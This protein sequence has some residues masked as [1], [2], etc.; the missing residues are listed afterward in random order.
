[1][2]E[3]CHE[4]RIGSAVGSGFINRVL[5]PVGHTQGQC[6]DSPNCSDPVNPDSDGQSVTARRGTAKLQNRKAR[7][8]RAGGQQAQRNDELEEERERRREKKK[9]N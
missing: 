7:R 3:E 4:G 9:E 2:E 6:A 8:M 1:M 5:E